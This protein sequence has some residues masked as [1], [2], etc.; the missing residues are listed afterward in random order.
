[1]CV[2]SFFPGEQYCL[3]VPCVT[4]AA[5]MLTSL[6]MSVNPCNDF[7]QYACGGWVRSNP[8]PDGRS[9]WG[10]FGKLEQKNQL[11][12]KNVLGQYSYYLYLGLKIIIVFYLEI[13]VVTIDSVRSKFFT[14]GIFHH[15]LTK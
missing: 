15:S 6:D 5:S 10:T 12:V 4:A 11:V 1:M 9:M 3:T 14:Y 7:Y 8:I 2:L 13:G